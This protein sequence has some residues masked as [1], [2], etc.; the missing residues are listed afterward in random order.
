MKTRTI[1]GALAA[2]LPMVGLML[3][4]FD[5]A[6]SRQAWSADNEQKSAVSEFKLS[7]PYS[8]GNL[9]IFL[10][11]G[12]DKIEGKKLLTLQEA[13]DQKQAIVHETE[14]VSQL[15]IENVSKD[16]EIFIQSGD[17]LKGGKQ[18]RLIS[19]T[20]IVPAQSG[21]VP[22]PAFCVEQ[23]RWQQRGKE[24]ALRFS[25]STALLPTKALKV[26]GGA[27]AQ[28]GGNGGNGGL[29]G[30]GF[31]GFGGFQGGGNQGISGGNQGFA[32]GNILGQ[33]GGNLGVA[34]G[35][36]G[37]GG[38][39]GGVWLGVTEFQNK[40]MSNAGVEVRAKE[41]PSGLQLTLEND[42]VKQ[43][44][45]AYTQKLA[46]L[47]ERQKD[48]IGY[49]FAINGK[50]NSVEVYGSAALFQKLWPKLLRAN[51]TEALAELQKGREFEPT[52]EKAVKACIDDAD[53]DRTDRE[54]V[55]I[56][57]PLTKRVLVR[58]QETDQ[59]IFVETRDRTHKDTWIH[60]TY[61]TK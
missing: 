41:S 5:A 36:S 24:A 3:V 12:H 57:K 31:G 21:K 9:T 42:K 27:Y 8:Y 33:G 25:S 23:G 32:G 7:G 43:A 19:F 58:M 56:Q 1:F 60:R 48:A 40:L 13:L 10:V 35:N 17:I 18:D 50:V 6:M 22:V 28:L 54:I 2:G 15:A 29:Q 37:L 45:D 44:V 11:H 30:Q 16:A 4:M 38:N 59:T 47:L 61:F 20:M 49:A 46:P 52:T 39:Q 53:R 26:N 34:G 55:L 51:A 14:H